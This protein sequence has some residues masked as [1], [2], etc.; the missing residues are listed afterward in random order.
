MTAKSVGYPVDHFSTN[1]SSSNIAQNNGHEIAK[2]GQSI[3]VYPEESPSALRR[4]LTMNYERDWK[5]ST[6]PHDYARSGF[7]YREIIILNLYNFGGKFKL[8]SYI[9][10]IGGEI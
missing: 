7:V 4:S 6:M 2:N 9:V 5:S 8:S 1:E 10:E 3:S